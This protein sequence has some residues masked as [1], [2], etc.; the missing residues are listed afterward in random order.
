MSSHAEF[1]SASLVKEQTLKQVQGDNT[2]QG[3][4]NCN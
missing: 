4:K 1:I 2:H 3:S